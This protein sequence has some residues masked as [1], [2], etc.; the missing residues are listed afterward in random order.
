MG[1]RPYGRPMAMTGPDLRDGLALDRLPVRIG[2][3]HPGLPPGLVLALTLQGDVVQEAACEAPPFPA[4][5]PAVLCRA[6]EEAV[7][8]GEIERARAERSL[9]R[10]AR[11]LRLLGMDALAERAQR[12]GS[13]G[14]VARLRAL[15]RLGGAWRVLARTRDV[16]VRLSHRLDHAERSL[17]RAARAD[18]ERSW[19]RIGADEPD[20]PEAVDAPLGTRDGALAEEIRRMLPGLEWGEA[21]CV[22][23]DLGATAAARA[24]EVR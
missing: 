10:V 17:A 1:G 13:P 15:L 4:P 7:P 9:R 11:L 12:A 18:A 20:D 5:V 14:A 6:R 21:L 23:A 19:N 2:P 8:Q 22:A 24:G 3:F 16:G